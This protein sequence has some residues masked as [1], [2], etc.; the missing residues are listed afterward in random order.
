M[1]LSMLSLNAMMMAQSYTCATGKLRKTLQRYS[2]FSTLI[3]IIVVIVG[4]IIP[5]QFLISYEMLVIFLAPNVII[6]LILNSIGYYKN[7]DSMN[8]AL[9]SSWAILGLS[10]V[11]YYAY[12]LLGFTEIL[13]DKGI[14]FSANDV[15][16]V[17]IILWIL[18]IGLVVFKYIKDIP[19]V[20]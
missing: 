3:Y 5:I 8:F 4:A 15:L 14:W 2:L 6:F 16:H 1:I 10:M 9:L 11:V 19:E 17:A 12:L 18:H 7:R 13:W 20:L